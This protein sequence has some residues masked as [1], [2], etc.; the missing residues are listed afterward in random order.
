MFCFHQA[1]YDIFYPTYFTHI[2]SLDGNLVHVLE[3]S[4]RVY[5]SLANRLTYSQKTRNSCERTC[6]HREETPAANVQI[7]GEFQ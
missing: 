5:I 1:C 4:R 2:K 7:R 6:V 3:L